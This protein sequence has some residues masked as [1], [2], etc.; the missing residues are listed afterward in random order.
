MSEEKLSLLKCNMGSECK[1]ACKHSYNVLVWVE[2]NV[3]R[4]ALKIGNHVLEKVKTYR[5]VSLCNY[6]GK[7]GCPYQLPIDCTETKIKDWE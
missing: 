3:R 7:D 2:K 5:D 1:A 6:T 4:E